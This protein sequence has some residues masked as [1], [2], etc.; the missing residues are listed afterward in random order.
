[1][2]KGKFEILVA[3]GKAY[4]R[5]QQELKQI[6][7][8]ADASAFDPLHSKTESYLNKLS[9]GRFERIPFNITQPQQLEGNN[10]ALPVS[11]LSK[12][13]KDILALALRLAAAEVY[14]ENNT[15]FV[16]MDDPLVDMD[17]NRRMASAEVLKEF[18]STKQTIIF[19]CHEEHARL[20]DYK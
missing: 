12:G 11:L 15:G 14:M 7:D 18:A 19:T 20:F 1:M 4:Q 8:A 9:S 13:T 10:I 2:A 17:L 5:I 6:L 3:E 16:I